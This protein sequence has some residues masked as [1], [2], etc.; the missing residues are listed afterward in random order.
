MNGTYRSYRSHMFYLSL[1]QNVQFYIRRIRLHGWLIHQLSPRRR[2]FEF[3]RYQDSHRVLEGR[4]AVE[5]VSEDDRALVAEFA[6]VI[7]IAPSPVA[8]IEIDS[9]G[10]FK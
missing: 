2:D 8:V 7:P 6:V 10:A 4:I 5:T 9:A 3:A 1:I